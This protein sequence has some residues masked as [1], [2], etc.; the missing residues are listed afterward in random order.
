ML[1]HRAA[2]TTP[3]TV[4]A[5]LKD[6]RWNNAMTNEI[7]TCKATRTWFLVPRTP[8]MHVLRNRWIYRNKLNADGTVGD[9][10]ARLVAQG[11]SQEE[12]VDYLET[13][14]P[15]VRT[16][17]VRTILHL[18][19]IMKWEVKQMDVK[20]AFLHGDL[21]ETVYMRQPCG[22]VDK[23]KPDH[24]CLLHKSLYGL[25]QSPRA[26]F[27]KFSD[28]LIEFGFVCSI[29]DPS[30]FIYTRDGNVIM[31]LLYVN[32]MA[33]TRNNSDTL[34]K[35][36]TELNFKFMMK[37]L[38]KLHYFLGIQVQS[39]DK[40]MFLS[41]EQYAIDLL[42]VAGMENCSHVN[43]PLPLQ[44]NNVPNQ[45]IPFSDPHYFRSLAG[46]LQYLTLTRPDIQ[47]AVN[48]VCQ[49]MHSPSVA[50]FTNLKRILRYV[51]G[52]FGWGFRL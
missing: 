13:Y 50:D 52:R 6:P 22:F 36:L 49:Q 40:G 33:I 38:G 19:T 39:H 20:N 8:E 7:D 42:K 29:K 46:K 1:T 5:A 35:L 2:N 11:N 15:V 10:R 24:V 9:P 34:T 25:K 17:T 37:D 45:D 27:N 3:S 31:L 26:W 30:L 48:Y 23:T 41:Q 18:A 16:A 14:S 51:K 44:L 21:A 4:A 43:T 28:F 47:F 32:D 12:G